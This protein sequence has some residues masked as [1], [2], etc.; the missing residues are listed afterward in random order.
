MCIRDRDKE[1]KELDHPLSNTFRGLWQLFACHAGNRLRGEI[2]ISSER[3]R[4]S[5][6]SRSAH[7]LQQQNAA[8]DTDDDDDDDNDTILDLYSARSRM[9]HESERCDGTEPS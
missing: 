1:A 8:N 7:T 4:K 5:N 2:W 6:S 3:I 9:K